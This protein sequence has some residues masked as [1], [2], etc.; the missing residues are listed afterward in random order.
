MLLPFIGTHCLLMEHALSMWEESLLPLTPSFLKTI[1]LSS[2]RRLLNVVF[3]LL[4]L[5][6]LAILQ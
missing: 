6:T 5:V 3:I 1:E 4:N 2:E